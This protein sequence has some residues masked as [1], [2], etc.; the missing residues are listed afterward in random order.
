VICDLDSHDWVCRR[1]ANL[2]G[3]AV[4]SVDYRLVPEHVFPA[5]VD[6]AA[7]ATAH[8]AAR[9][10]ELS[11][12]PTQL[13]V[14]GDS[15]GG[16]LAAAIALMARDGAL[17]TIGYQVLIYPS[18]DFIG[19]YESYR[20]MSAGYLLTAAGMRWF[21]NHYM[22]D[23]TQCGDWRASPIRAPSFASVAPA[24][25]LTATYDPL[26]D[27]GI[28]FAERLRREGVSVIHEHVSDQMHGYFSN[29]RMVPAAYT[30]TASV[31]DALRRIWEGR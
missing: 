6:D 8:I 28:A 31:A 18:V 4:A 7:A 15:A 22:P 21:I 14:G 23:P 17:P 12:N 1:I 11:I 30:G 24:W 9:A 16:N 19:D 25:V 13:A 5:A 3:C 26:R 20:T 27:E 29:G 2:A 10:A